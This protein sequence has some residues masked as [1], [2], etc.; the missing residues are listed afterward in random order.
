MIMSDEELAKDTTLEILTKSSLLLAR[1][2][3]LIAVLRKDKK[4]RQ[5]RTDGLF[6]PASVMLRDPKA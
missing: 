2:E 5:E 4:E 3:K 1:F 6:S